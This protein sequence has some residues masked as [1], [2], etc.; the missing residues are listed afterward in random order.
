MQGQ[1]GC[2]ISY[3]ADSKGE[4]SAFVYSW[5]TWEAVFFSL[6]SRLSSP[7]RLDCDDVV[8]LSTA[9]RTLRDSVLVSIFCAEIYLVL[10]RVC[11]W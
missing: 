7:T 3:R 4:V 9:S 8:E 5:S 2:S 11:D 10:V 1:T 6:T